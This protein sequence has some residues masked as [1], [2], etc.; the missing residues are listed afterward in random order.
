MQHDYGCFGGENTFALYLMM[1]PFGRGTSSWK[2]RARKSERPVKNAWRSTR[3][4]AGSLEDVLLVH[5]S[6]LV[7]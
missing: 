1:E 2:A 7:L 6:V 3:A 4:M 5:Y